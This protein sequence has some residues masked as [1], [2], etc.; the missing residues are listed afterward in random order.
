MMLIEGYSEGE[1]IKKHFLGNMTK[2]YKEDYHM[3][4]EKCI[5]RGRFNP[6]NFKDLQ[7]LKYNSYIVHYECCS[8]QYVILEN[9]MVL[10][11]KMSSQQVH[12]MI[13]DLFNAINVLKKSNLSTTMIT[14]DRVYQTIHHYKLDCYPISQRDYSLLIQDVC[15][16]GMNI[17][18]ESDEM[19]KWL[20]L[21][22][23]IKY[24]D[25]ISVMIRTLENCS[26]HND[27]VIYD[28]CCKKNRNNRKNS[29]FSK[30]LPLF[31]WQKYNIWIIVLVIVMIILL[32]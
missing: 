7:L 25:S 5:I 27:C 22:I 26:V 32:I 2:I 28:L 30:Q 29:Y 20:S 1:F 11:Q 8:E 9:I 10:P 3:R 23:N 15:Q 13:I 19:Y 16:I 21:Y 31:L 24:Q 6:N 17:L 4:F 14:L 12:R 18:N